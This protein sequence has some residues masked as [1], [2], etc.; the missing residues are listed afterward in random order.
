M[1]NS[2]LT[3]S[4]LDSNPTDQLTTPS[5]PPSYIQQSITG[6]TTPS[7][8]SAKEQLQILRV[9]LER[10]EA[11]QRGA[12]NLLHQ[13]GAGQGLLT[14]PGTLGSTHKRQAFDPSSSNNTG[15]TGSGPSQLQVSV[16]AELDLANRNVKIL[17]REIEALEALTAGSPRKGRRRLQNNIHTTV[18][19]GNTNGHNPAIKSLPTQD[20]V[21]FVP[22]NEDKENAK[23]EVETILSEIKTPNQNDSRTIRKLSGLVKTYWDYIEFDFLTLV[24]V[25]VLLSFVH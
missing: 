20:S 23:K 16:E 11:I 12:E 15:G 8:D 4:T 19:S 3:G 1:I 2:N 24:E 9:R 6:M 21:I 25:F 7:K 22:S 5:G 18:N 10:A 14:A 13:V 17:V